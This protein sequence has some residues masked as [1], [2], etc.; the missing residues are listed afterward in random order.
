MGRPI[1]ILLQT[2]ARLFYLYRHF[3]D[4]KSSL[5]KVDLFFS[6]LQLVCGRCHCQSLADLAH[7]GTVP[8][9]LSF[10]LIKAAVKLL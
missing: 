3:K 4:K 5:P 1:I 8:P 7:A 9:L 10:L 6:D 2:E